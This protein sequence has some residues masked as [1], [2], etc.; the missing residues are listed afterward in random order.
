MRRIALAG[1]AGAVSLALVGPVGIASAQEA[2]A[3]SSATETTVAT[4]T[5][6]ETQPPPSDTATS[7]PEASEAS[8]SSETSTSSDTSTAA[9]KSAEQ[10]APNLTPFDV[11]VLTD[12]YADGF[13]VVTVYLRIP[14]NKGVTYTVSLRDYGSQEFIPDAGLY[15]AEFGDVGPGIHPL[16]VTG[17]DGSSVDIEAN[18]EGC[19]QDQPRPK[20]QLDVSVKCA[21]DVGIVTIQ[22]YNPDTKDTRY[23]TIKIDDFGTLPPYEEFPFFHDV[24]AKI[25]EIAPNGTYE[26]KLF[27]GSDLLGAKT[28]TVACAAPGPTPTSAPPQGGVPPAQ[29]GTAPQGATPPAGGLPT[30]GAAVRGVALL[31]VTAL[32]L[33]GA[34]VFIARR[35]RSAA[36]AVADTPNE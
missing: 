16:T 36:S 3:S 19:R 5:V 13:G 35:R 26:I 18:L 30:T 14:E 11:S 10:A 33:G 12:C 22:V 27:E 28:I 2:P 31:G 29:G 1:V 7:S 21:G 34:L 24:I 20:E 4:T 6:T 17:T 25:V 32:L 8:A 9:T 23:L 15:K